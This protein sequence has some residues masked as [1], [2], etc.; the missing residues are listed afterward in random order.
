M[1]PT[2]RTL[3]TLSLGR[4]DSNS[5]IDYTTTL[6]LRILLRRFCRLTFVSFVMVK[7]PRI[8]PSITRALLLLDA[9]IVPGGKMA[10]PVYSLPS[11]EMKRTKRWALIIRGNRRSNGVNHIPQFSTSDKFLPQFIYLEGG[12]SSYADA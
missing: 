8:S 5:L 6:K 1:K 10:S 11:S 7:A 2:H 9:S 4:G 12:I 3:L